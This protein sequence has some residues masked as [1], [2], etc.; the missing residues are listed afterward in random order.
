MP[1]KR[2]LVTPSVIEWAINESGYD[3][4]EIAKSLETGETTIRA[5]SNGIDRPTTGQLTR[6]A[7]KLKRPRSL[8]FPSI[9]AAI[10]VSPTRAANGGGAR[11]ASS[12]PQRASRDKAGASRPALRRRSLRARCAAGHSHARVRR[13]PERYCRFAQGVVGHDGC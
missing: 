6:L 1:S 12:L 2:E 13:S 10:R 3:Y 9:G 4:A 11:A 5:W 7:A 8:F